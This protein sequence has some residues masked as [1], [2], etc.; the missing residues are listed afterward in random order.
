M[1]ND[2]E[3]SDLKIERK[4]CPK[5]GATWINGQHRWSTG[6]MGS[7]L[8]L[9]GLVCNNLGDQTCINPIQGIEGGDTWEDRFATIHKLD[10]EKRDEFEAE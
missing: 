3:L 5:C 2:K 8:D 4:E 1:T 6:A 9:A 10:R 7:E